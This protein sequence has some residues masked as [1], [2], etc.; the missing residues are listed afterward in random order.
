ML[1]MLRFLD[2]LIFLLLIAACITLPAVAQPLPSAFGQ[3]MHAAGVPLTALALDVQNLD[4]G[5]PFLI[6]NAG[7]AMQPASVMKLVTTQAALEL[8]GPDYRWVTHVYTNGVQ[9]GDTL[10][11]DLFI[12]G[13]GD[14][15]FAQEDLWRLLRRLRSLG[16]RHISGALV[17]D[18]S[19]FLPVVQDTSQ[20]D[21]REERAYNALP[22]ALLLDAKAFNLQVI[23]DVA[24]QRVQMTIEPLLAGFSVIPPKLSAGECGD[25]RKQLA[26]V[27][28]PHGLR[29]T[30]SY[31]VACG[32]QHFAIHALNLSHADFF[33]AAFRQ[34]WGELGGTLAGSMHEGL[35]PATARDLLQWQSNALSEQIRD[36]NKFSNNVMARQLLLTMAAERGSVPATAT[37]GGA[38]VQSWLSANGIPAPEM[39]LENG[40]GLSRNERISAATLA[41]VLQ[42]AWQSPTMPEYV[43]SLPIAGIDGTMKKRVQTLGVLG[44]AHIKTGSLAEVMSMA[45]YITARS[46]R[47]LLVV[48]MVN[49]ANAGA[50]RAG[51]DLLLQW[52]YENG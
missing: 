29:F 20:F 21:G 22:D 41:R 16:V 18:R 25:W 5:P 2:R 33:D 32:E 7:K 10:Q 30:G 45:G 4:G 36:I 52:V 49:H 3:A 19:L 44:N 34:I 15:R 14:P 9:S 26:L 17:L 48:C 1:K 37:A 40:S 11:G 23:P 8:L 24:N 12:K 31:A 47:H 39:V 43:A 38:L 50:M 42:R 46:G 51:F 27:F 13:S 6:H 28:E 35:V